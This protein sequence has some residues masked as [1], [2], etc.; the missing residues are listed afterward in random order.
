MAGNKNPEKKGLRILLLIV[1][2][3]ALVVAGVAIYVRL[4]KAGFF[5]WT[6]ENKPVAEQ[7]VITEMPVA[8]DETS[9]PDDKKN[10]EESLTV[11]AAPVEEDVKPTATTPSDEVEKKAEEEIDEDQE[12]DS[13]YK[14]GMTIADV[15]AR[16][17]PEQPAG[18][19]ADTDGEDVLSAS[20]LALEIEKPQSILESIGSFFSNLF[21]SE[22]KNN[23]PSSP[24]AEKQQDALEISAEIEEMKSKFRFEAESN[25]VTWI[26]HI[27]RPN[28]YTQSGFY[29]Y[30]GLNP[31]GRV[32]YRTVIQCN[33]A[34]WIGLKSVL[35][36][37]DISDTALIIDAD[38][39]LHT[40]EI[41]ELN[42][43]NEWVDLPPTPE[44]NDLLN[45]VVKSNAVKLTFMGEHKNVEWTLTEKDLSM[46]RESTHFY[47]L[48]KER[49]KL[50]NKK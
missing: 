29:I 11:E 35:L 27:D 30:M 19:S 45:T 10:N 34:E 18:E 5:V 31:E 22:E 15:P 24:S 50:L 26:D 2:I 21:S 6:D 12:Y 36:Q 8:D 48:L 44:Y 32:Y 23:A 39:N 28:P 49:E 46:L 13:P 38:G 47:N 9:S 40:K 33:D 16:P 20:D 4:D 25:G 7:V 41:A 43:K 17:R 14:D 42:L 3:Y 37:T 1:F